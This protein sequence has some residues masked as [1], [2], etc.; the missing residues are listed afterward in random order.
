MD[1]FRLTV[2]DMLRMQKSGEVSSE[3]IVR[4]HIARIEALNP[5]I[6]ALVHVFGD[7]A[8]AAAKIADDMRS[9]N[10]WLGPLHGVPLTI[11]ESIATRGTDVTLGVKSQSG[12]PAEE[13]ATIVKLLARA[14]GIILGKGN[15]SQL[16]LFQ[17]ADNPIWGATN[18]PWNPERVPGGSSGGEAAAIAS[19]MAPF[20]VGTDIGGSIRVPAA[21]T[22]IFGLK[23]TVDRW[24]MQGC[25]GS[26]VGQELIR[27]QCGPLARSARDLTTIM[28]AVDSHLQSPYDASVPP[29]STADPARIDLSKLRVGWYED[30]GFLTPAASVQRAVRKAATAL[31]DDGVEVF[32]FSPPYSVE[33]TYLYFAAL[34]SDGGRSVDKFLRGDPPVEQL[35]TLR[36][37]A[38]L[39]RFARDTLAAFLASTGEMRVERLLRQV[40]EKKVV[41]HWEI[42]AERTRLRNE[43]LLA[44]SAAGIDA[45]ICPIHPTP[46]MRHKQTKEFSLG[47]CYAMRYNTL[48]FP[49]GIVPVTRAMRNETK[50]PDVVDRLDRIMA[51]SQEGSEGL[52]VAVQVVCRPYQEALCLAIMTK[53]ED[54]LR[55]NDDFPVT[56]VG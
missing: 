54:A 48:N 46:A 17:E 31:K 6:N 4:A 14:G 40:Y 49:A 38:K 39:P 44:W 2:R 8:I 18:N 26:L 53:L 50:R 11:K 1:L 12:D 35:K 21:F 52:P 10:Q 33:L 43:V 42:A 7:R 37:L 25:R 27:S 56:P 41:E 45:V 47:G 34:S 36:L 30:D 16:L 15:I 19:G 13:D 29:V 51:R 5:S 32:P 23:P 24:S 9:K 3:E 55:G 28:R 20:G 22:G